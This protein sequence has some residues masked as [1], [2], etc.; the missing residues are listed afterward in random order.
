MVLR[1]LLALAILNT[2]VPLCQ[3][4][5]PSRNPAK[6]DDGSQHF[7]CNVGYSLEECKLDV[8]KLR[9]ALAAYPTD[10][11]RGW[12]W[13]LV[14]S[15]E[16]KQFM[17]AEHADPD[18][19]AFTWPSHRRI[20]IE[21]ALVSPALDRRAQLVQ[22]WRMSIDE[23]L[24]LALTHE[25]GHAICQE[26]DERRADEYARLVRSGAAPVCGQTQAWSS[27]TDSASRGLHQRTGG[28]TSHP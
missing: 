6:R 18:S 17:Q 27:A 28:G 5:S 2:L 8:A 11:L 26:N 10:G 22:H 15:E 3:D 4:L 23:L 25:M 16:W 1:F 14:R 7:L 24:T 9:R 12:T 21:N 13:V 19:P 20:F